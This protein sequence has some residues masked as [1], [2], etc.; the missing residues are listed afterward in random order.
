M[1]RL[2]NKS[3]RFRLYAIGAFEPKFG[4]AKYSIEMERLAYA[5]IT[6]TGEN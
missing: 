3:D 5:W 2:R 4:G 1:E 6:L